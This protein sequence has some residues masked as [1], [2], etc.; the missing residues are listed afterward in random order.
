VIS[1]LAMEYHQKTGEAGDD[2][3]KDTGSQNDPVKPQ[4][5]ELPHAV[6]N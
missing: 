3:I 4:D 6:D 5:M 2:K 1:L